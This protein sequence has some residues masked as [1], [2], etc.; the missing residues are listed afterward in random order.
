MLL[1]MMMLLAR[2]MVQLLLLQLTCACWCCCCCC[3]CRKR[4]VHGQLAVA[5]HAGRALQHCGL[6]LLRAPAACGH[7]LHVA[8]ASVALCVGVL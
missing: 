3:C 1:L 4:V 2:R 7:I 8:H 5:V 6:L